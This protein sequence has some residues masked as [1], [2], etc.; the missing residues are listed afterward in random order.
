MAKPPPGFPPG[1]PDKLPGSETPESILAK[2]KYFMEWIKPM[3]KWDDYDDWSMFVSVETAHLIVMGT[4]DILFVPAADQITIPALTIVSPLGGGVITT[5]VLALATITDGQFV[6][7]KDVEFPIKSN[8][9]KSVTVGSLSS[10]SERRADR[11]FLGVRVGS[12]AYFRPNIT[13][14]GEAA[15]GQF[16]DAFSTSTADIHSGYTD[17]TLNTERQKTSSFTH[18]ADSAEVEVDFGGKY[19]IEYRVTAQGYNSLGGDPVS[20]TELIA[21]VQADTGSG[22]ADVSGSFSYTTTEVAYDTSTMNCK[23]VLD[24]DSGDK[25]KIQAKRNEGTAEVRL[26]SGASG[27]TI[28]RS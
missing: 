1:F 14:S 16:F 19:V 25:I 2:L 20:G 9:T 24:L 13:P 11:L 7:I 6:Y 18:S 26:V 10:K 4:E 23:L 5:N 3:K 22:Y 21:K 8:A 28:L 12:V 27:M 15:G 17:V